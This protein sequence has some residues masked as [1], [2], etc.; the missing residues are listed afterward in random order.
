[1][2]QVYIH[3]KNGAFIP[4]S[5]TVPVSFYS[6]WD[7]KVRNFLDIRPRTYCKYLSVLHTIPNEC[8]QNT[9]NALFS[10][11]HDPFVKSVSFCLYG[12]DVVQVV[13]KL[14]VS[15]FRVR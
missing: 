8:S 6:D 3:F 4:L 10:S 7:Y 14:S 12:S 5:D 11:L 9:V 13:D 2:A 15:G 1:M